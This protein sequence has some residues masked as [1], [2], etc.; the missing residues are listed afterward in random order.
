MNESFP[1]IVRSLARGPERWCLDAEQPTFGQQ[2]HGFG[3]VACIPDS[4]E[5]GSYSNWLPT[6]KIQVRGSSS[7]RVALNLDS[8]HVVCTLQSVSAT[9]PGSKARVTRRDVS[10]EGDQL[11]SQSGMLYAEYLQLDKVL[12]AQRMLSSQSKRTVHDEHLFIITH[13][14]YELWFKQIIYELDYVRDK[15]NSQDLTL[16]ESQSLEILKRMSRIVLILKAY[17]FKSAHSPLQRPQSLPVIVSMGP[18]LGNKTKPL[19]HRIEPLPKDFTFVSA[20]NVYGRPWYTGVND[21]LARRIDYKP[22]EK[23]RKSLAEPDIVARVPISVS[24]SQPL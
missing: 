23:P 9:H 16:D 13:Q 10:Q 12:S 17:T 18:D 15:F 5:Q 3:V 11:D 8:L 7:E 24:D 6:T 21:P 22:P 2:P 1:S 4:D 20:P 14:A 19:N